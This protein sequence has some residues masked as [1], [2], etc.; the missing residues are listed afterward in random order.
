MSKFYLEI[1]NF[2]YSKEHLLSYQENIKEWKPNFHYAAIGIDSFENKWLDYYP[3]I[4]DPLF[5]DITT[6]INLDIKQG[7]FKFV[8]L[9]KGGNLPYHIDPNRECVFMIPITDENSGIEWVDEKNSVLCSHIY[10]CP[11]VINAKIM[12]GVPFTDKTRVFLQINLPCTWE[13]LIENK[14]RIFI[15]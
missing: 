6:K 9:L 7:S 4:A 15:S 3:D 8:T 10:K 12:H 1:K 11:T 5:R 2:K 13:Y 14:D